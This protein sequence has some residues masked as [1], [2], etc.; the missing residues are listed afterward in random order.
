MNEALLTLSEYKIGELTLMDLFGAL[1]IFVVLVIL[2]RYAT[3]LVRR[4]IDRSTHIDASVK[5]F[6]NSTVNVVLWV[7]IVLITADRLGIPITTLVA[8]V[9]VVGVALSLSVQSI[10]ENIFAG[11]TILITKPVDVGEYVEIDGIAGTVRKLTL[12]Y[13]VLETIDGRAVYIPNSTVTANKVLNYSDMPIR[14]IDLT[15]SASYGDEPDSVLKALRLAAATTENVLTTPEPIVFV[16]EYG[17]S[18]IAYCLFAYCPNSVFLATK[19]ALTERIFYAFKECG[20]TMTYDHLNV[21]M[22]DQ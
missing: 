7:I 15:V 16:S 13:T 2:K 3:K 1:L 10:L 22:V 4:L 18:S 11:M 8:M 6:L 20:V 12:F 5:S 19:Y 17:N 14:R 9:S 21:H